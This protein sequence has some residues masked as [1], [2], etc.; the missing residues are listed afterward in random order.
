MFHGVAVDGSTSFVA[1][2]SVTVDEEEEEE[3][4]EDPD[5]HTPVSIGSH[6]RAS[7][8]STTGSSPRKK[9][10]SVRAMNKYMSDNTKIEAERNEYF[11]QHLAA[12][13]QKEAAKY[14]K[15]RLVRKLARECGVEETNR[16]MWFAMHMICNEENSMEF[17]IRTSTLEGRLTFIE[18]S[19]RVK[20]LI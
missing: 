11:K 18:H 2:E 10:P 4:A 7:S 14:E 8:T 17:F 12:K 16:Q 13:Q 1:G 15:I 19:T 6:K 5:V 3:A 20:G 9:S